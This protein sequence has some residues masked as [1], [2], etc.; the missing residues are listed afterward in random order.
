MNCFKGLLV[1]QFCIYQVSFAN[2]PN[3]SDGRFLYSDA[4]DSDAN[5]GGNVV[6]TND[7]AESI[8]NL[9]SKKCPA[10]IIVGKKGTL[11]TVAGKNIRCSSCDESGK[12]KTFSCEFSVNTIGSIQPKLLPVEK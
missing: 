9:L 7:G 8:F 2:L 10:E 5:E 6:L 12:N 4:I 1:L 11:R 3:Y